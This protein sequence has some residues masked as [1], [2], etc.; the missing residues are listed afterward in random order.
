MGVL[1]KESVCIENIAMILIAYE[2]QDNN[3][4]FKP[5][6]Q[7]KMYTYMLIKYIHICMYRL[8]TN[9]CVCYKFKNNRFIC[10]ISSLLNSTNCFQKKHVKIKIR[11][12]VN[13]FWALKQL[14]FQIA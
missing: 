11:L 1:T 10:I 2:L 7:L 9:H 14:Q 5:F 8:I 13:L 3:Y 4:S 12:F 6:M